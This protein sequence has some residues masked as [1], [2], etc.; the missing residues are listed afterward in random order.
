MH[1]PLRPPC[2]LHLGA[3]M[4]SLC[5]AAVADAQSIRGFRGR[6]EEREVGTVV[7]REAEVE[8]RA[9]TPTLVVGVA[10][11]G[12]IGSIE[13]GRRCVV[14]DGAGRVFAR[15]RT[16]GD[17]KALLALL[18]VEGQAGPFSRR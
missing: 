11:E 4:A 5:G 2:V 3:G 10:E 9:L 14:T 1:T 16:L 7:A 13:I 18:H 6:R 17:A 15:L 8:W 12:V